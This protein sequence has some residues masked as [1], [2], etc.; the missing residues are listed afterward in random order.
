MMIL[1]DAARYADAATLLPLLLISL[2]IRHYASFIAE[3]PLRR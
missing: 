1:I 2:L 3:L